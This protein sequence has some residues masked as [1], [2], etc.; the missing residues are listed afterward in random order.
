VRPLVPSKRRERDRET[1]RQ[2]ETERECAEAQHQELE[3]D[4]SENSAIGIV[5]QSWKIAFSPA[6]NLAG[7]GSN[8]GRVTSTGS[9][10]SFI[11]TISR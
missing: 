8:T 2:R 9:L 10:Q 7:V 5:V 6:Q 11:K 1:E 4:L 3:V